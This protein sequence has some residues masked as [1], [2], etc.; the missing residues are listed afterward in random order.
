[1]KM[2]KYFEIKDKEVPGAIIIYPYSKVASIYRHFQ[3]KE[4]SYIQVR[5]D[6]NDRFNTNKEA[7]DGYM[8]YLN[9]YDVESNK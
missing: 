8:D 2:S 7:Y 6:N 9:N 5:M 1:M 3:E 4:E